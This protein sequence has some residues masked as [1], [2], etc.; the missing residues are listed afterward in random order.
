MIIIAVFI[1]LVGFGIRVIPPSNPIDNTTSD[2]L[3]S[4][5]WYA[6][7]QTNYSS[8][9]LHFYKDG[10]YKSISTDGIFNSH[11]EIKSDTLFINGTPRI[12]QRIKIDNSTN[13]LAISE[14]AF[15]MCQFSS[16]PDYSP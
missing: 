4:S 3:C 12:M 1:G 8:E 2:Y 7:G 13:G 14:G 6:Y 9:R 10:T 15:G 5:L 16:D 11:W